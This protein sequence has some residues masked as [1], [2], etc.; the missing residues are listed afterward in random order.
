MN[1][2]LVPPLVWLSAHVTEKT[3]HRL[4]EP[5]IAIL[6]GTWRGL[7]YDQMAEESEFSTNYLMRDVAPKLWKQLSGIFEQ[8]VSKT[9]FRLALEAYLGANQPAFS[10]EKSINI[11]SVDVANNAFV[12]RSS[13]ARSVSPG[14]VAPATSAKI[15]KAD[16]E[17]SSLLYGYGA[18]LTKIKH[19]IEKSLTHDGP[20]TADQVLPLPKQG[21]E[22]CLVGIW[23]LEGVGKSYL[24]KA[25]AAQLESMF[26]FVLWQ[27]LTHTP[28][29]SDFCS[30][31]LAKLGSAQA[32]PLQGKITS[33]EQSA[34]QLLLALEQH[35]VLLIVEDVQAI[36]LPG[37][38]AGEYRPEYRAYSDF[39]QA[40]SSS[41]SC[42]LLTGTEGPADC[43]N[44]GGRHRNHYSLCLT[45]LSKNAATILLANESLR[46]PDH[47]PALIE[48]YQGHPLALQLAA[49][50]IRDMFNGRVDAFLQQTSALFTDVLRLLAPSFE[51]L[52]EPE[53]CILYWLASQRQP[54]SLLELQQGLPVPISATDLFSA[55]DSL[56]QRSYLTIETTSD[57]PRFQLPS[58][59]EAYA[60]HK[61]TAQFK[62]GSILQPSAT[63]N[64]PTSPYCD[65]ATEGTIALSRTGHQPSQ[66]SQWFY[67]DFGVGWQPLDQLLEAAVPGAMRLCSAYHLRDETFL[68]RCKSV[69]LRTK[70]QRESAETSRKVGISAVLL[71]AV[72]QEPHGLYRVCMQAQPAK[73]ASVLPESIELRLLDGQQNLL[74]AAKALKN[75][76]F[77]QLPYFQGQLAESFGIELAIDE[78]SY[79]EA[80]TV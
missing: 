48:R 28:H 72:R 45:G 8:S 39:F 6:R 34:H 76:T 65:P 23:G 53:L 78:F 77:I 4:R 27:S 33:P 80:F 40:V 46:T 25:V 79:T 64:L 37:T 32:K 50:V 55:L 68:K 60:V 26:D 52:S 20:N 56:K 17:T 62:K 42:L 67:G 19:W 41:H 43:L 3:G 18:E 59:I 1:V 21:G 5:E 70:H 7:T 47:W 2:D 49:R 35:C 75:D 71:L 29:V 63:S 30:S 54:L 10:Q 58:L 38:L 51:R 12:T 31:I 15:A 73:G 24:C 22:G 61:L 11:A 57:P 66:L 74:T 36:L 13:A 44:P 69:S 9:N 14:A 16:T